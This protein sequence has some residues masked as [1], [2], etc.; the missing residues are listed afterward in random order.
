MVAMIWQMVWHSFYYPEL[1]GQVAGVASVLAPP[2]MV[3][4]V[5]RPMDLMSKWNYEVN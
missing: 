4:L 5:P 3:H 1:V 2:G